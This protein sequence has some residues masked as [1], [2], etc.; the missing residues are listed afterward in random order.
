MTDCYSVV[1][2]M[3]GSADATDAIENMIQYSHKIKNKYMFKA[4]Y[5]D[6]NNKIIDVTDK[7]KKF[8]NINCIFIPK[9]INF[10]DHFND[11]CPGIIKKLFIIVKYNTYIIEENNNID[12]KIFLE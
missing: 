5:G 8:Q 12:T 4:F 10:N 7:V 9:N 6:T 2:K 3:E 11:V 1:T